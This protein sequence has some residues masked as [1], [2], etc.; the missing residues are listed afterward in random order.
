MLHQVVELDA[1]GG[2]AEAARCEWLLATPLVAVPDF[3]A[4]LGREI[5]AVGRTRSYRRRFLWPRRS[6]QSFTLA[7]FLEDEP[8]PFVEHRRQVGAGKLVAERRPGLLE[9]L[10]ELARDRHCEPMLRGR[11]RLDRITRGRQLDLDRPRRSF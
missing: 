10:D 9:I 4:N 2:A 11:Q 6:G 3:S 7:V 8:Q 1:M 5:T